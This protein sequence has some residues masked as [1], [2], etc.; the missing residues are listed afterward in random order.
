MLVGTGDLRSMLSGRRERGA[1]LFGQSRQMHAAGNLPELGC[2]GCDR[3]PRKEINGKVGEK[4][5]VRLFV[6]NAFRGAGALAVCQ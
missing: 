2:D 4:V 5:R 6:Q 1:M 3:Q